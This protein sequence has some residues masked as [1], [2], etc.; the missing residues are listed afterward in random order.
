MK[1]E[2]TTEPMK[3]TTCGKMGEHTRIKRRYVVFLNSED[4]ESETDIEDMFYCPH[5]GD[6][7]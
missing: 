1:T 5:C 6:V 4:T 3:C 2:Q 7:Y